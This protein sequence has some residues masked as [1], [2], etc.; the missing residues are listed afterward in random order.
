MNDTDRNPLETFRKINTDG[1]RCLANAAAAAGV[2]RFIFIS[3]IKVNGEA[4]VRR[5]FTAD[6]TPTPEDAYGI[7]KYEAEQ[8]L[9]QV[10][11]RSGMEVCVIRPPLVY[12]PGVKGN[13]Q[14]LVSWVKSGVP[15][16]FGA[17]QNHRSLVSVYNLRDLIMRCIT[18]DAARGKVFLVSDGSDMSIG[19]LIRQLGAAIGCPT[20]LIS[21]P[22]LFL[23]FMF[24]VAGRQNEFERLCGSLQVDIEQT[25]SLLDWQPPVSVPDGLQR[26]MSR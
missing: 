14:R 10:A 21:M 5:A 17:I 18:S 26:M 9:W 20:R 13:F 4:T 2:R 22:P 25:C 12:G 16:P 15:L 8:S 6:D 1:T 19:E 11:D 23:K 24:T 3:S 7:S